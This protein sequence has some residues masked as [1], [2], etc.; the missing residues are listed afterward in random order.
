MVFSDYVGNLQLMGEKS[1]AYKDLNLSF[2]ESDKKILSC[3]DF[4]NIEYFGKVTQPMSYDNIFSATISYLGSFL[5]KNDLTFTFINSFQEKK[6]E[7]RV[8]LENNIVHTIAITTTYYVSTLPLLEIMDFV[9]LYNK[10]A[11]VLVGGP[12]V[13][14]QFKIHS[15]HSLKFLLQKIGADFY[16]LSSQ[17]EKALVNII[18]AVKDKKALIQSK[19]Y[20]IKM[21]MNTSLILCLR[22][23]IRFM[24]I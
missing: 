18:K 7:L 23:K 9:K 4:C 22:R 17:G 6:E 24:K 3:R 15:T 8:L 19:T 12:F 14:T 1:G 20:S 10:S 11:K 16:V 13:H 5:H 2:F 21:E